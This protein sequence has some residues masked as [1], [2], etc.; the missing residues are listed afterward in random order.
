MIQGGRGQNDCN[1]IINPAEDNCKNLCG[2]NETK[3][4]A[5][6]MNPRKRESVK[7]QQRCRAPKKAC[8]QVRVDVK[9]TTRPQITICRYFLLLLK[10]VWSDRTPGYVSIPFY[11]SYLRRSVYVASCT[12]LM[13]A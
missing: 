1:K 13:Q 11:S 9:F 10:S 4:N 3:P 8:I 5:I 2:P 7:P 6:T 12:E